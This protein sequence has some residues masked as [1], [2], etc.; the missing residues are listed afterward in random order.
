MQHERGSIRVAIEAALASCTDPLGA[1]HQSVMVAAGVT[2]VQA[3]RALVKLRIAGVL[4][5]IRHKREARYFT[6][7]A[8][9]DAAAPA[10]A[11][12]FAQKDV[13]R[14]ERVA[15][16]QR[17]R[18]RTRGPK[19]QRRAPGVAPNVSI[20]KPAN[21]S[22]ANTEAIRPPGLK[23][24]R[25]PGCPERSRFEPPPNFT[26]EFTREWQAKRS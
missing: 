13:D 25:I 6:S 11:A 4:F 22:W 10:V 3:T 21:A 8:A 2:R 15:I 12:Y 14:R 24:K 26:G 9:R 17:E 16:A 1:T 18:D 23:V 5:H 19:T 7:E 20:A